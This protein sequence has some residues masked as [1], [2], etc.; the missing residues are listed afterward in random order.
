MQFFSFLIYPLSFFTSNAIKHYD[1]YFMKKEPC[2]TIPNRY[3][4]LFNINNSIVI[5]MVIRYLL[6]Y[7]LKMPFEPQKK[8]LVSCSR[9]KFMLCNQL[10]LAII[11]TLTLKGAVKKKTIFENNILQIQI[12]MHK[13]MVE[14]SPK[15]FYP[16]Y[17]IVL[18]GLTPACCYFRLTDVK[19]ITQFVLSGIY[20]VSFILL[21]R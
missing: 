6:K 3:R 5:F 18:R 14:K 11:C 8:I 17:R 13:V 15:L 20:F 7:I 12:K 1:Y 16:R 19:Y 9:N 2:L 4:N 10:N 21:L